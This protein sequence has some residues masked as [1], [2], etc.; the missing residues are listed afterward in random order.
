M[1]PLQKL[2]PKETKDARSMLSDSVKC[3]ATLPNLYQNF[4]VALSMTKP[5]ITLLVV[6]TALPAMLMTGEGNFNLFKALLTM[7][8]AAGSSGSAAIF[9]QVFEAE[10]Y[11]LTNLYF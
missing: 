3:E 9:N 8:G 4:L 2:D 11:L 5:T 10:Y 1:N 7:L 6:I